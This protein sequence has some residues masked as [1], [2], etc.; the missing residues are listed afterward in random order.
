M[1]PAESDSRSRSS[2]LLWGARSPS[3]I[4]W[5]PFSKLIGYPFYGPPAD[6]GSSQKP[7]IENEINKGK[8]RIFSS[9]GLWES[10]DRDGQKN[11]CQMENGGRLLSGR[12]LCER[13]SFLDGF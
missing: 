7:P 4:I 10:V 13:S 6:N 5:F 8:S 1:S 9:M 3:F 12:V 11:K 2:S